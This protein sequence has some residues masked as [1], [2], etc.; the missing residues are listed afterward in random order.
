MNLYIVDRGVDNDSD[1]RE[2]DGRVFEFTLPSNGN[3][4]PVVNAGAD[5]TII[6][7]AAATLDATA[8][9][10]GL[11]NPPGA[12]T[13]T[14]S[15]VSGPGT[16]TFAN[17]NALQTTVNFSQAGVYVLSLTATDSQYPMVD[18]VTITV[19][20]ANQPPVVSAGPDQAAFL[21]TDVTLAGT[22]SDDGFPIP[23]MRLSAPGGLK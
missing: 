14:W 19:T 16:V 3:Q 10:D 21:S 22:V 17:A 9:D 5:Q 7:P 11:P 2:N 20:G 8:N 15:K 13:T 6:F 23:P 12:L 4:P 18:E 1:P